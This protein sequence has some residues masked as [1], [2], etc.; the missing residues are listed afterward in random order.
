MSISYYYKLQ[1]VQ[2]K[3]TIHCV[4]AELPHGLW[5]VCLTRFLR[6]PTTILFVLLEEGRS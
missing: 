5:N 1:F 3:N 6:N 2:R 4:L